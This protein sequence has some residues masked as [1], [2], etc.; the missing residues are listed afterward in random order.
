MIR[1]LAGYIKEY[2]RDTLLTPTFVAL[3]AAMETIIPL[4]MAKIIDNGLGN[5]DIKYVCIVGAIMLIVAFMSL[6]FG[7]LSGKFAASASAG[8]AANLRKGMYYNIQKFSFNNID[9]Y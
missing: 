2:K 9:K 1:R 6:T 7:V 8:F 5:R 3:E 4:L